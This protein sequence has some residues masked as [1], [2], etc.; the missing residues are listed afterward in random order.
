MIEI[1]KPFLGAAYYPEDWPEEEVD[2]DIEL[3]LDAGMDVVRIGEFAW[4]KMEPREGE[5]D[6]AWL[7]R[8]VDKLGSA[9]IG[10]IMGTPTA[11]PPFWLT[12]KDPEMFVEKRH[13]GRMQHG[14]RRHGCVNNPTYL[15]YCDKIV[16]A[17]AREFG[18]DENIIGWQ[19][20]NEIYLQRCHCRHCLDKFHKHLKEKFG[21]VEE[22]NRRWN[23]NLFSQMYPSFEDIHIPRDG[24][25]GNWVNPHQ[26]YE[27]KACD[28]NT[29]VEFVA[30]QAAILKKYVK[31]PVGTDQMP[32]NAINYRDM[33]RGLD[34]I[35]FNHYNLP[36]NLWECG[37]WMD[38]LRTMKDTPFWNTETATCWSGGTGAAGSIKPDG[39][40]YVNS[41]LPIVL[42]GEANLY[43]LWRTHW[44]GHELMHGSVVESSG[45]PQ[46]SIGEVRQLSRDFKKASDFV[47][48]TKV[49]TDVA[50]HFTSE[51]WK[52]FETQM[53][54]NDFVYDK[55]LRQY[56]YKPIIDSGIRPDVIDAEQPLDR[57]KVVFTPFVP[58]L[59]D[60]G[61]N[62]RISEWVK[63]GGIWVTGPMT[64]IRN[65][66]TTKFIDR[67]HGSLEELTPAF[68]RY[69]VPDVEKRLSNKWSDG[70]D[71]G[72]NLYYELFD[73]DKDADIVTV[74][75]GSRA[76][77]G[78]AVMQKYKVG[79]GT[80]YI[81]G[82]L[83]DYDDMR[84]IITMVCGDAG[85]ACDLTEGNSIMV[86]PRRGKDVSGVMLAEIG[87][88]C[89]VYHNGETLTDILT[90]KVY[91]GNIALNPYEVMILKS[92]ER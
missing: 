33:H 65:A 29:Q 56:F 64:D 18:D 17:L 79:K 48:R 8:V 87:N 58:S 21:T 89:G 44:A 90:G 20:D 49:I 32:V 46:Y 70:T 13:G 36:E 39:F 11:V 10:V 63:G 15:C 84:R 4:A 31:A 77:E 42:G 37:L 45:R 26:F 60:H 35:Q 24:I 12:A 50:L 53:V 68:C 30:R 14:G 9:G 34:V 81:L 72:G 22:L 28:A 59:E 16:T 57:Y 78:L 27:Y 7:H 91:T 86:S 54:I 67:L 52:L 47:S 6:F 62:K 1:K 71:F 51:S 61:L 43:W 23:L 80:V 75:G 69:W 76:V 19:I 85:I 55:N 74:T 41:W 40:C 73:S 92:Q 2:H 25:E 82:T 3:M 5:Y 38:Y 83:P 88:K 66:D